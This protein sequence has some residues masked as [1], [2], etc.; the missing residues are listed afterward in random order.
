MPDFQPVEL[1][2]IDEE[3]EENP[4][5]EYQ[6]HTAVRP[7][8]CPRS[9]GTP[10]LGGLLLTL[11]DFYKI[12]QHHQTFSQIFLVGSCGFASPNTPSLLPFRLTN[13]QKL[14]CQYTIK[15]YYSCDGY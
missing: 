11:Q 9:L 15:I 2:G 7:W 4:A 8:E 10:M 13:W 1:M 14:F 5:W 6:I 3:E 12:H